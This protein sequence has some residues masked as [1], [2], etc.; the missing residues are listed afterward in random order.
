MKVCKYCGVEQP[1]ENFGVARVINGKSYRRL[2]CGTCK[3]A[4][5][6]ERIRETNRYLQELKK[7]LRCARCGFS[8][9]RALEFHHLDPEVKEFAIGDIA[10]RGG[11]RQ[12]LLR[13]IDKCVVLCAN[14]HRIEHYRDDGV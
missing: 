1:V 9:H 6:K 11:S 14:C 4:R 12:S 7:T 5:Q 10:R 3:Y 2:K 8:D 13:E